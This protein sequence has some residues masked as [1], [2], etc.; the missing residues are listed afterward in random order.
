MVPGQ[1]A[2]EPLVI[3]VCDSVGCGLA[4]DAAE[5]GDLGANTLAHVIESESPA[6]PHFAALGLDRIAGVP[7]LGGAGVSPQAA[8]GRLIEHGP[9]K[10]TMLGHWELMGVVAD[11]PPPLYPDGFPPAVVDAFRAA[12]GTEVLGNCK[13]SGTAVL[14]DL[15]AEHLRSGNPILYTSGDSV[16]QLAAHDQVVAVEDLYALCAQARR[17]LTG[18]HG[19]GRVIARPFTGPGPGAFVRLSSKRR[20]Y[21]LPPPARTT[22]DHLQ[23]A[24]VGTRAI[25]KINDVF[26]GRGISAFQNAADNASGIE[27]IR[28]SLMEP[29]EPFVF[30]NLLD[31]DSLYGHRN[32]ATGYAMALQ[33]LDNAIPSWLEV[34]PA[35]GMLMLTAD[36]G[37]DPTWPGTDHTRECVPLLAIGEHVEPATLGSRAFADLGATVLANFRVDVECGGESFLDQLR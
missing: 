2:F 10:D 37:N 14:D 12:T 18:P 13:A 28:R 22:L 9:G 32:D 36:H 26:G 29:R 30:A 25:G 16:F 31:F 34:L 7:P 8:H 33:E 19:V 4:P 15:G 21:A 6:L 35:E 27:A 1:R 11:R 5:F 3:V 20:D 23:E 17:L 24:G